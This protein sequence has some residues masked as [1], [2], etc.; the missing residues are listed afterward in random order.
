MAIIENIP[1][2][3]VQILVD[4][5]PVIEYDDNT[6]NPRF[7]NPIITKFIEAT[8]EIEFVA[9][10]AFHNEFGQKKKN[11]C[12]KLLLN[13]TSVVG[14]ITSIRPLDQISC[15]IDEAVDELIN[16]SPSISTAE[17]AII[18]LRS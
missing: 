17:V 7:K 10:V 11:F 16:S 5:K 1:G 2:L 9:E 13:G 8:P 12:C 4:D 14:P 15:R 18:T 3:E 6:S